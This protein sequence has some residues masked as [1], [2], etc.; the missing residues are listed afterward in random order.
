MAQTVAAGSNDKSAQIAISFRR[1]LLR[2]PTDDERLAAEKLFAGRD[3]QIA[4]ELLCQALLNVN[5]F[6]YIE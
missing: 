3:A 4:L 1:V 5:E 6:A 2:T